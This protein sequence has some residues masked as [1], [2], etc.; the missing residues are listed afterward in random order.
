MSQFWVV[1]W[2]ESL[3]ENEK[4]E[5]TSV[6]SRLLTVTGE[7]IAFKGKATFQITLGSQTFKQEMLIS[8]IVEKAILGMDLWK[9]KNV[10]WWLVRVVWK[11]T[12]EIFLVIRNRTCVSLLVVE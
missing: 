12:G 2:F 3:S 6:R 8:D 5:I 11:L 7:D 9:L 1:K 10:T 4:P